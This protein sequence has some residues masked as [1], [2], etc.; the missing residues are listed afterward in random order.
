MFATKL[1]ADSTVVAWTVIP[2][3]NA[4]RV[5]P[6]TNAVFGEPVMRTLTLLAPTEADV[7]SGKSI[8]MICR[9][10]PALVSPVAVLRTLKVAVPIGSPAGT[11]T[12]RRR[13][14][15]AVLNVV[16]TVG[17]ALAAAPLAAVN[18]T[19][20]P[21]AVVLKPVPVSETATEG[22]APMGLT[23]ASVPPYADWTAASASMKE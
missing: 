9:D 14:P 1:V 19:T 8:S 13:R 21:A 16:T 3:P 6:A 17:V 4:A 20:F 22:E 15:V 18:V 11:K 5:L 2:A 7:T 10:L 23:L 12:V